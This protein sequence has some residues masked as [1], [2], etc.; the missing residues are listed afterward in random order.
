MARFSVLIFALALVFSSAEG[1]G[2]DKDGMFTT[3]DN[4]SCGTYLDA[5]SKSTLTG[6]RGYSGPHQAWEV[7][8]WISGYLTA[9]NELRINGKP[10]I[11]GSMGTNDALRWIA[12]WCRGNPSTDVWAALSAFVGKIDR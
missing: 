10:S 9:Y 7:F 3:Y 5:Y 6:D 8:G 2:A 4:S 12:S 1:L 11:L